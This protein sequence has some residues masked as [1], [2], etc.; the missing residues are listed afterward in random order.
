MSSS[1]RPLS[2]ASTVIESANPRD[3]APSSA[4]RDEKLDPWLVSFSPDDSE[5]PMVRCA[6]WPVSAAFVMS[7]ISL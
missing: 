7:N 1:E 5:N 2:E 3:S 4:L 6:S